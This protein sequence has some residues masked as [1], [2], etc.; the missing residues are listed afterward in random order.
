[1]VIFRPNC[2]GTWFGIISAWLTTNYQNACPTCFSVMNA[3]AIWIKVCHVRS[4]NIFEDWHPSGA[5]IM[6][7]PFKR[8]HQRAFPPI[9]FLSK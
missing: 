4:A 6:L 7:K 3:L 2:P 8:I 1:M 9:N 5:V